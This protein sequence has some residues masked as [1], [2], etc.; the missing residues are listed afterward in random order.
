M[1][2]LPDLRI[3]DNRQLVLGATACV[4]AIAIIIGACLRKSRLPPSPP[5][6]RLWGHFLPPLNASLTVARWIDEYGPLVTIRSGIQT[7]V[8]I[9]R[10]QAAVDIMEKQSKILAD[11]PHLPAGEI[12]T[13]GLD[14]GLANAGDRFRR[15]QQFIRISSPN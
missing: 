8:I 1:L 12:L 7:T 15:M 9:G 2:Y 14:I 13:R 3:S 6:W 5:T 4:W 11:R 10:H